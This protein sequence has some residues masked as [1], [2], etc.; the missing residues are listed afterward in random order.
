MK[1]IYAD[2]F[3]VGAFH[4][5]FNASS[6]LMF[7][8]IYPQII[9][10]ATQSSKQ[11]VEKLVG[12]L[13]PN[14][15][16]KPIFLLAG[17]GHWGNFLRY[18]SSAIWNIFLALFQKHDEI[19]YFNYNS[20][21]ATRIVNA[22]V[23][24][25]K[26][27]VVITCHGELEYLQNNIKLNA[28]A[29]AGLNLF[30]NCRWDIADGLYFCVL[31][32]SIL[33]NIPQI[34]EK[35]HLDKFIS[36]E[37]SFIPHQLEGKAKKDGKFRIGTVGTIREYKGLDQLLSIGNAL[38]GNP[39]ILFYALGRVTCDPDL[40]SQANVQFIPG[41][42][43][44]YVSKEVLNQYIDS[45]DSLIFTYPT[46]KY[47]F[48]ASGAL[49]DAI[50]REKI[51]LSLH[52][53]YFD[54]IYERINIGKQFSSLTELIDF[55]HGNG[56]EELADIDFKHNKLELSYKSVAQTLNMELKQLKLL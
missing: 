6:L 41:S 45:M 20:L 50:D 49:F 40:L 53:D 15:T 3:S 56:W 44:D 31:G 38:K 1:L 46:D 42:E 17:L 39:N 23:K 2:T 21:W 37:H 4:E 47:K 9:Y 52:N 30:A 43:K 14:V 7:A 27:K 55:L 24:I 48:T 13:P 36:Y 16:Y 54:G 25:R 11:S 34:V 51:I 10:R 12:D 33:T 18:L 22:I 19:L 26:T 28:P 32:K 29:Q 8:E 5:T 35:R